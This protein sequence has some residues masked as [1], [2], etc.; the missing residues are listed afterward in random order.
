[1]R[2]DAVVARNLVKKYGRGYALNDF[3]LS[4]PVG[5][6]MGLVGRNGAGKTTLMM[7]M[8]GF[9]L[10]SSGSI[11]ILRC[12]AF[13]AARHGGR[14]S[15]LPQDSE[16][17]LE[18]RARELLVRYAR[19]QGLQPAA[20]KKSADELVAAFNLE[21]HADKR[22]RALSHGMRK[23]IMV[24]QAF[25][26]DPAIVLLDE[27]LS[28]LDPL[29]ADRMRAFIRARRGRQTIVISSHN[30]DDLEKLCTHVA[31]IERGRL[32]RVETL[33]ALTAAPGRV[34]YRLRRRPDTL[35]ALE[36]REAGF[37]LKWCDQTGELAVE[38]AAAVPPE[39]INAR[40]LPDLL[41]FGVVSVSVGRSLEEAYLAG[42]QARC[43]EFAD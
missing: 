37:S 21:A 12:G 25:I 14:L 9:V 32:A 36:R 5:S 31:L 10:P 2:P 35:Q 28:G 17:P 39:E 27:P 24:A 43:K 33:S 13:N 19:L 15:I 8:A 26:G 41:P 20:A 34:V 22:I 29:E 38:V 3:S 23:R 40:W 7:I 6:T 30:L 11:D 4:V 1:M 42:A 16:L 18:A